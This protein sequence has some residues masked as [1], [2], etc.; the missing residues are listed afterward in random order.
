[1]FEN[2]L[3]LLPIEL[4]YYTFNLVSVILPFLDRRG[5]FC[6]V[7]FTFVFDLTLMKCGG[8]W[9]LCTFLFMTIF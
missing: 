4:E 7:G 5:L 2:R 1:M 9:P 3:G 8:I 6:L